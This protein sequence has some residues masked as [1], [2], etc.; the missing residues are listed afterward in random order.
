MIDLNKFFVDIQKPDAPHIMDS[1][2]E[3]S[4]QEIEERYRIA[5]ILEELGISIS[6]FDGDDGHE[7]KDELD[8]MILVNAGKEIPDELKERLLEK[9]Y[10]RERQEQ[11]KFND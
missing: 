4:K 7:D 1:Q 8:A 5:R 6:R 3:I 9:K 10:L 2:E 11:L